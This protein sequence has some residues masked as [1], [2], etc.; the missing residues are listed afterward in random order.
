M[1]MMKTF[2]FVQRYRFVTGVTYCYWHS[3]MAIW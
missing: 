2:K 1:I 3:G